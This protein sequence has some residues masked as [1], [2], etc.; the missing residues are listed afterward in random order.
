MERF[1]L[2]NKLLASK[3]QLSKILTIYNQENIMNFIDLYYDLGGESGHL[4]DALIDKIISHESND[5]KLI[6]LYKVS[7]FNSN[8]TRK[9]QCFKKYFARMRDL[10]HEQG[11]KTQSIRSL[12]SRPGIEA[13]ICGI[14]YNGP[15]DMAFIEDDTGELRL[16]PPSNDTLIG[17]G[18]YYD[19]VFVLMKGSYSKDEKQFLVTHVA[20]PPFIEEL[21]ILKEREVVSRSLESSYCLFFNDVYLD[22]EDVQNDFV[23]ALTKYHERN[24]RIISITISNCFRTDQADQQRSAVIHFVRRLGT[25][26]PSLLRDVRFIFVPPKD[27]I[28]P[29]ARYSDYIFGPVA[30]SFDHFFLG[31]NPFLL[32]CFGRSVSFF[33]GDFMSQ[34]S[35][36][37]ISS[38]ASKSYQAALTIVSQLRVVCYKA[39]NILYSE[40][41][42]FKKLPSI[43]V[44]PSSAKWNE[45]IFKCKSPQL[46]STIVNNCGSFASEKT[47]TAYLPFEH[48]TECCQIPKKK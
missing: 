34:R 16:I 13:D 31:S 17:Q 2:K 18:I 28:I 1:F 38:S 25:E 15:G 19:S 37:N 39:E 9:I 45:F 42:Y 7:S 11:F 43:I 29:T 32:D 24:I 6:D 8:A 20:Q 35:L 14:L 26:L 22:D 33:T 10:I 4:N 30:N 3:A 5:F 36:L 12:L 21:D 47:W 48:R 27:T 40:E 41:L 44:T 46:S 23:F